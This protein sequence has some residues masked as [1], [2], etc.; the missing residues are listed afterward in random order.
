MDGRPFKESVSSRGAQC[1]Q[2]RESSGGSDTLG[3][4]TVERSLRTAGTAIIIYLT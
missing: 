1:D 4:G 2:E 3:E